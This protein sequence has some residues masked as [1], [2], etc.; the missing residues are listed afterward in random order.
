MLLGLFFVAPNVAT[1]VFWVAGYLLLQ[2]Q[3]R[4]EEEFLKKKHGE[5]YEQYC[6]KVH[7]WL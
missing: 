1:L 2:I 3:V 6:Q 7:R 5:A 4:L